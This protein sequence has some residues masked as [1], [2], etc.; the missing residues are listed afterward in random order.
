M[1]EFGFADWAFPTGVILGTVELH[2][3]EDY[4][5]GVYAWLL[6]NI[7][8]LK[9]PVP[10]KGKLNFFEVKLPENAIPTCPDCKIEFTTEK[11]HCEK[12]KEDFIPVG[13]KNYEVKKNAI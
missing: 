3:I 6:R 1:K 12:C 13:K 9:T 7:R 8:K 11:F 5:N 4:G 10:C 2:N